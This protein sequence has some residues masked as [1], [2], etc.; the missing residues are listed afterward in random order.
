MN[1]EKDNEIK[2]AQI[3]FNRNYK[4]DE[5]GIKYTIT[6]QESRIAPYFKITLES[7]EIKDVCP[8]SS[9][10]CFTSNTLMENKNLCY[11]LLNGRA[12]MIRKQD[13]EQLKD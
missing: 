7:G 9:G 1:L 13:S 5:L 10:Y 11:L 4:L 3:N 8:K 2:K 12:F 6:K